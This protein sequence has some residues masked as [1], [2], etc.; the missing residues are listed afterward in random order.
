MKTEDYLIKKIKRLRPKPGD[1][2]TLEF[3]KRIPMK[4]YEQMRNTL[5]K[6]LQKIGLPDLPIIIVENG[7][8]IQLIRGDED[9]YV[10]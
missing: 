2:L 4:G 10:E 3:E 7:V 9:T 8:Q 5:E 1:I 6:V